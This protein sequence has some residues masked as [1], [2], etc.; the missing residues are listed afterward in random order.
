LVLAYK[1]NNKKIIL[2]NINK[3]IIDL[4]LRKDL[5]ALY[6]LKT[7]DLKKGKRS[8]SLNLIYHKWND[9]LRRIEN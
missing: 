9:L 6:E 1:K 3:K 2:D 5:K 4:S 7:L 8:F